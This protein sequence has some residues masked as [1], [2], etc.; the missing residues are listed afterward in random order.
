MEFATVLPFLFLLILSILDFGLYF[1]AQHTLQFATR[2]GVRVA[3]VGRTLADANGQRMT[4]AASIVQTISDHAAIAMDPSKIEI[5]IFPINPDFTD[6][7]GWQA[8]QDAG[9]PGNYMRVRTRYDYPFIT[10]FIR[11][12]M[13]D[14]KLAVRAQAT[15]RNELFN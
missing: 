4:R 5:S 9:G 15:Y 6:P 12:L 14:G 11:V 8:S 2:E 7:T 1:F 10:P 13:S 3:L